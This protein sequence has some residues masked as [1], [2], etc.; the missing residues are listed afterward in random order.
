MNEK[1]VKLIRSAVNSTGDELKGKLQPHP[2][3]PERNPY[4]HIW[5][6]IKE[7]YGVSYKE[8]T[9]DKVEDILTLISTLRNQNPPG[10]A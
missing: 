7:H 3:H 5:R 2:D 9:D 8:L 6:T 1:N 4:A 10:G